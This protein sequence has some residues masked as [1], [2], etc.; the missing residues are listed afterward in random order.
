VARGRHTGLFLG[1]GLLMGSLVL[2]PAGAAVAAGS[3]VCM[4][5]VV[6]DGPSGQANWAPVAEQGANVA[7]GSS[8]LD[9]LSAAGDTFTPNNS[10]LICAVNNYPPN[11]LQNCLA[12]SG[13]EYDYWSYWQGDPYTDTWNYS[14]VGPASHTISGGQTYVEGWRYEYPGPDNAT[15]TKPSVTPATAFA[16]ACPGVTPVPSSGGGGSGGSGGASGGSGG[17]SGGASGG[18]GS[19]LGTP[20]PA[21][22]TTSPVGGGQP[23]SRGTVAGGG[24]ATGGAATP[25]TQHGS[26]TTAH[27]ATTLPASASLTTT[28]TTAGG[29]RSA[30][31][32][33]A[34]RDA[35]AAR[36]G[37]TAGSDP[38]LP[39]V[40]VA[41]VIAALGGLAWWR[42]HRRPLEE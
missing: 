2:G 5:V 1:G 23:S 24:T 8:D 10:G 35:L 4:G 38:A 25:T 17:S 41:L 29:A 19:P 40:L 18:G 9:G 26:G 37:P 13:N 22:S 42:W 30:P 31:K 36:H 11:G 27:A 39:V 20:P 3:Q 15:A 28:T 7:P 34:A 33:V 21:A 16:Q 14:G 32:P 6:D 12:T